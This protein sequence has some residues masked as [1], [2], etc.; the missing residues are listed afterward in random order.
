M[1]LSKVINLGD[2]KQQLEIQ[3]VTKVTDEYGFSKEELVTVARARCKVEF[4]DRLMR[5]IFKNGGVDTTQ[6]KIFV[7]RYIPNLTIADKILFKNAQ[8]EIYGFNNVNE[9]NRFLK[10]W[11]RTIC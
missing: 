9:E 5:E 3:R 11:A 2:L 4:D 1:S 6:A 7:V 8:Y 10:I